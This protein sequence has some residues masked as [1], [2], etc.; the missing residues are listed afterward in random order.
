MQRKAY[1]VAIVGAGFSGPILAAKISELGVHPKTGNRL[2]VAL[3]DAGPYFPGTVWPGHGSPLR[4]QAFTNLEDG[5][6]YLWGNDRS[7]AK[8]VGGT[9]LHWDAQAFLPFDVDYLHWQNETGVDWTKENFQDA[10]AEIRREFN[11][12]QYP[13]EIDT[14][15][16]KLFHDTAKLMGYDPKRQEGARRNCIYC[17]YCSSPM[18]CKYDS[19]ASTVVTYIPVA[20]KNGVDIIPDTEVETIVIDRQAERGVARSLICRS[21]DSTY[22]LAA[23]KIIVCCGYKGTPLLLMR[24]GYG[25]SEWRGNPIIVE[26]P[27]IGK[28]V[29]GHPFTPGVSALFDELLGD[30]ELGSIG[31]YFILHDE[32]ADGEG[33]LLFRANF[34]GYR[35]PSQAS[36]NVFA[37][38]YGREHKQFM[39]K[40]GILR[41][42]S[43]S[44]SNSKPSGRWYIDPDGTML[45]GGDHG[46]TIRRVNEGREMARDILQ[47]MGATKITPIDTPVTITPRTGGAHK[48]GSCRAGVDSSTSVVNQ[49]FESHDV[50]NLLVCD[51]SVIPRVTTGNTGT[52]QA[53]LSVFAASRIIERHF[54]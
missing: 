17:G 8:I 50:D 38:L 15:G 45:Y 24:S 53:S 46:L 26:N 10:V 43:L 42:G 19:R 4:R 16:N 30:G 36:L 3:I 13:D 2:K 34:G 27:N 31:G 6:G 21:L 23:D 9:S 11:I 49:Y 47:E 20:E 5:Y 35:R 40:K 51:G 39:R 25:P 29:D 48:V 7:R 52:P 12:H 18:M 32:Q 1:D 33:R 54:S 22:E 37:P 28:H 44:P 41:T 14:R